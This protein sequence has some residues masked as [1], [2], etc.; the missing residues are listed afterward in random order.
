[1]VDVGG[2]VRGLLRRV[3]DALRSRWL[4]VASIVLFALALVVA[5]ATAGA[6]AFLRSGDGDIPS[7]TT[8]SNAFPSPPAVPTSCPANPITPGLLTFRGSDARSCYGEGPVPHDPVIRWQQPADQPMCS[9]SFVGTIAENWCG[10]GWTGQP[11]VIQH[12]DGTVEVR[13][14]AYDGEYHFYDGASGA[15]VRPP[16]KTRD[17]AKGSATSDPDGYPLY[18]GGSRD[19][20]FR[21]MALDRPIPMVLWSINADVSVPTPTWNNDWDG[22]PLVVHGYLIEGCENGY[23]YIVRLNRTYDANH[24]VQVDPKI[25]ATIKGWDDQELKDLG[26]TQVSIENSV[27]FRDGVVYFANSGGLVQG[28]DISDVLKGGTAVTQ[29]LRFW[30]GDDTDASVTIDDQGMLY[31]ASEY[32]RFNAR[33]QQVGQLMK[34]DPTKPDDPLVWSIHAQEIGFE[35]AGGSWSTP[36]LYG[37]DVYFTTA[38][39]RVLEVDRETG[40]VVWEVDVSPPSIGSPVVVDGVL[41]QGDCGGNLSAWDVSRPSVDPPPLLWRRHFSGCIESTPAVWH[42]WI[43][44]GTR[45]GY[46]YG[47]A[48]SDAT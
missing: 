32:Q 13:E 48:D 10:T 12:A 2:L 16:L 22:A 1:M 41:L 36:A 14:G 31:V 8:T 15:E 27:S 11:N 18:Y 28:W 38:A 23:L 35:G 43:F 44:V 34:L 42:G 19:N 3:R 7:G 20:T 33:A 6:L 39:G 24:L 47:L 45:K 17:L 46:M 4:R 29:V 37:G 5:A 40:K 26:D 30:T 9:V 21:V 25:V